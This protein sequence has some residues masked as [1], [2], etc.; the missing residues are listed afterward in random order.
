[1]IPGLNKRVLNFHDL[2]MYVA[3]VRKHL[4]LMILLMCMSLMAG[5]VVY[6]YSRPVYYSKA[7]VQVEMLGQPLDTDKV[8]HDGNLA[9]VVAELK[10]PDVI[11]R[12]AAELGVKARASEIELKYIR[13][14]RVTPTANGNL[15]VEVW[16]YVPTWPAQWTEIMVDQFMNLRAEMRQKQAQEVTKVYGDDIKQYDQ[17]IDQ[18]EESKFGMEDQIK[19]TDAQ[20]DVERWHDLPANIAR[21]KQRLEQLDEIRKQLDKPGLDTVDRLSIIALVDEETPI[22]LGTSVNSLM[23]GVAVSDSGGAEQNPADLTSVVVPGI[24]DEKMEWDGLEKKEVELLQKKIE[25]SRV[26]LPGNLK[27]VAVQKEL[28][29]VEQSLN[30]DYDLARQRF[31]LTY[32]HLE[33]QYSD[34]LNQLPEYDKVNREY[35]QIQHEEALRTDGEAPWDSFH[36]EAEQTV[37]ELQFT[38]DKEKVNLQYGQMLDLKDAPV[39]PNRLKLVLISVLIGLVLAFAVPFLIEYLDYT[40]S[41]LEEVEA[42]F[43]MRG[44]GIIPQVPH[45]SDHPLLLNITASGDERNLVE[46]FRVVRTNLL[47]MGTISKPAHVTMVTSAM[48]KEGKT[49]VAS[50]LAISFGQ[51]GARTLLI[52]VD[53]RRGRLHRLFGLRKSPGLSDYLLDKVPLNEAIRTSGKENLFIL[54]AGQHVD[55]GTELLGSAK[56]SELMGRLR[57]EYDRIIMDTPPILGLSETSV[58]QNLVDGV[59]FVIWSGRTPIR[60]MKT[61]VDILTANGANFY[62]FILNRLDLSSTTNYYQYY[63][64]SSEY[65]HSYHALES[66]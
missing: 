33:D 15:E 45:E 48:P 37:Q 46:N 1:M 59:L 54:S 4:R 18:E 27:M 39:A 14:I 9:A 57:G 20:I 5:L 3:L 11:E 17:N 62:G 55:S 22:P 60:N 28:D 36:K 43:Q 50:N 44:L 7:A 51:T 38:L 64:Y 24:E 19:A 61:A 29:D 6:V 31:E 41:N 34:Y 2:M 30:N 16:S 42:T 40:L 25:L 53:L 21:T 65:Y 35:E 12:T 66:A 47:A 8:Y 56:F 26:F 10:G 58:L 32:R 13:D 49:V 23:P 63:Y 52:D